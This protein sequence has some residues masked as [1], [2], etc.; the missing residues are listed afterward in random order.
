M[1]LRLVRAG[2]PQIPRQSKRE[3]I[4]KVL[5]R[6]NLFARFTRAYLESAL[7]GS[8]DADNEP[9]DRWYSLDDVAEETLS[10]MVKDCRAFWDDNWPIIDGVEMAGYDFWHTR[11]G[12]KVAVWV[13]GTGDQ[14]AKRYM[15][16]GIYRLYVG[17]DGMI[18]GTR[19]KE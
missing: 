10:E 14:L 4:R 1:V 12:R 8:R 3:G 13:G 17:N 18:H 2:R 11:N 6:G 9:M 15:E 16:A 7:A 5:S 19:K